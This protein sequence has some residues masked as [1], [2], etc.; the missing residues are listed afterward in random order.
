[1]IKIRASPR[2]PA[3][4][5]NRLHQP[6]LKSAFLDDSQQK[7]R[8]LQPLSRSDC[9]ARCSG[10]VDPVYILERAVPV[11]SS[12]PQPHLSLRS[13]FYHHVAHIRWCARPCAEPESQSDGPAASGGV[14][15]VSQ[16]VSPAS[17]HGC[18][19]EPDRA[20]HD[21]LYDFLRPRRADRVPPIPV[22]A[23]DVVAAR[24]QSLIC[25]PATSAP[26]RL[27]ASIR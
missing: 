19:S 15:D 9:P 25:D 26:S 14:P 13:I 6:R 23:L 24:V 2:D 10:L 27:S 8:G 20:R 21:H 12:F 11:P 17:A 3:L 22:R 1:M 16:R 18:Q 4:F 5:T 7:A